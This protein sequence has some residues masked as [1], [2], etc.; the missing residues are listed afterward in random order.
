MRF[1]S[2]IPPCDQ[3]LALYADAGQSQYTADPD[4]LLRAVQN[5]L[6]VVAAWE[7]DEL[8]G[9]ARA[10]GDGESILY[11]QEVLV[12][13]SFHHGAVGTQLMAMILGAYT[14]VR[15]VVLLSDNSP[16]NAAYYGGLG[17]TPA[18]EKG[19]AAYVQFH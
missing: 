14:H 15:H 11:I 5:S 18:H 10:V 13:S 9:L 8:A 7:G 16:A 19:C 4:R 17:F 3:L 2:E 12:H 1:S 6:H